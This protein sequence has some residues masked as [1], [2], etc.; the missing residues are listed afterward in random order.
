MSVFFQS[1]E[2][3]SSPFTLPENI[4]SNVPNCSET[5]SELATKF[6][7]L[8]DEEKKEVT[9][10]YYTGE[11][12]SYVFVFIHGTFEDSYLFGY[13]AINVFSKKYN[14]IDLVLPGHGSDFEN[15]FS[16]THTEWF[17]EAKRVVELAK[18]IGEKIVY[19]T[20]SLGSI[21]ALDMTLS[22]PE[23]TEALVMVEPS[24]SPSLALTYGACGAKNIVRDGRFFLPI[25]RLI[26]IRAF[27]RPIPLNVGC[28]VGETPYYMFK[29]YLN[30][31]DNY[32]DDVDEI[33]TRHSRLERM[34]MIAA[35]LN[36]KVL[37]V[38]NNRDKVVDPD[39][40]EAFFK[41]LK[42]QKESYYDGLTLEKAAHGY[43]LNSQNYDFQQ[44]VLG[45][46]GIK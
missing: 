32:G 44:L 16:M 8:R 25:V 18:L 1:A 42:N 24:L 13:N 36:T 23:V 39:V 20:H 15:G 37:M 26:G 17:L 7:A 11:K 45:Y 38:N 4:C 43:Y 2:A 30:S 3:S 40:N 19:V 27:D 46:L 33:R 31:K 22:N 14:A 5:I 21:I 10:I 34:K 28:E 6:W 35:K 9:R 41:S 12:T 29:K